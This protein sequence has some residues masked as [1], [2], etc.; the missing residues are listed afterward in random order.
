MQRA[1]LFLV[2]G[3]LFVGPIQGQIKIGDNPQNIDP[4]SVLEL[5]S[6]SRVLVITR[7][8]TVEMNAITPLP[9][10]VVYNTD[11]QCVH[12]Y[13]GAQW[14]NICEEVGGIPNL[15]TD[16]FVN[17]N[18]TLVIT[19]NGE[20]NHI[21]VAPNSIRSAQIVDGGINGIDIQDNS[22]GQSKIGND[23][24]GRNE[25]AENAVGLEALDTDEV[26]LG[27]LTNTPGFITGADI[28][29]SAPNNAL[30]DN[31]G[32]FYNNTPVFDAIS[33]N[34]GNIATNAANIQTNTD[35]IALK[36]DAANKS[37]DI[38]LGNSAILFPTQNAVKSYV[39]TQITG[40][41]QTIV[42]ANTPNS[43]SAGTD[44]GALFN[45]I[46]LQNDID[47]NTATLATKEDL[48]NKDPNTLLGTS[49]TS[50]PTQNAVK[51]YVDN[52]V[53]G[54]TQTIVSGN[55]PNSITSGTDG[56]ALYNAIPL[57]NSVTANTNNLATHIANDDDTDETNELITNAILNASNELVI[58]EP[59]NTTTVNLNSLAGGGG[60]TEVADQTT[61]TGIG[62][63]GDPFTIEPGVTGQFLNT[64]AG[65]NVVWAGI[66]PGGGSTELADQV[67]I[68]GD[69]T[70]GNEFEVNDGAINSTKITD[71]TILTIDIADN[72]VTTAKIVDGGVQTV[73]LGNNAVTTVKILDANVTD[74]KI[75][76]GA[77]DQILRTNATGTAVT[78]VDLPPGG[79]TTELAD[80]I[81]ITGDGTLANEFQVADAGI[82]TLQLANNAV[83]TTKIADANV[84]PIKIEPGTSGQFLSTDAGNNVIW[85]NL[86]TGTG[87]TVQ[88]DGTTIVGNGSV[89]NPLSV[90]TGGIT[91][92]QIADLTIATVD[93]ADDNVTPA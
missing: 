81:T 75:A 53:G 63:A 33:A 55:T 60:S 13:D 84:T 4:S 21:E 1:L 59:G 26:T 19:P 36:E 80:Q 38:A 16:P 8:N 82:N 73:D 77:A 61:I 66:P 48:A 23:A 62:T 85:D 43:I 40:S 30:T 20:N 11:L 76:P 44:G 71:G 28:V 35:N 49:N 12:Y 54:S 93:I 39:D 42:S 31:G 24:V 46:P 51:V 72:A 64:D 57:Q 45:A 56:G 17:A 25:I 5:E 34:S 79:G 18:S 50:Y 32:A 89:T 86:P 78:W 70:T 65:G 91:T 87:G 27:T 3:I 37:D 10:A 22:I 41:T 6:N 58:T 15:T 68:V 7:V 69:G 88:A 74:A 83:I 47:A 2:F 9:G 67:T 92:A 29:S 90:P 14:V 52:V